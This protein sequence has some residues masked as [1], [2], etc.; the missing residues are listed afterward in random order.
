MN[1]KYQ[2]G[3][4]SKDKCLAC[5]LF[6]APLF[7]LFGAFFSIKN[8][9][10]WPEYPKLGRLFLVSIPFAFYLGGLVNT[11]QAYNIF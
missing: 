9:R 3:F 5:K 7:F 6:S 8:Y 4:I 11:Y 10:L 2:D 1:L